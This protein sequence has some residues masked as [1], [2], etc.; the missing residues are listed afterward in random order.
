MHVINWTARLAVTVPEVEV[1]EGQLWYV[2]HGLGSVAAGTYSEV[3]FATAVPRAGQTPPA[4]H[5]PTVQ[6]D[7]VHRVARELY[8][9]RWSNLYPP[10]EYDAAVARWD[11]QLRERIVVTDLEAWDER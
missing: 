1:D 8:G 2:T 6:R 10:D 5:P 3:A 11:M 9:E 4:E 7:V